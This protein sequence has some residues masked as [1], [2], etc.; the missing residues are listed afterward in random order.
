MHNDTEVMP[1]SKRNWACYSYKLKPEYDYVFGSIWSGQHNDTLLFTVLLP[2][3]EVFKTIYDDTVSPEKPDSRIQIS[4]T[5][6]L[7]RLV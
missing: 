4:A 7:R 2:N 6:S 5:F 1:P 3:G